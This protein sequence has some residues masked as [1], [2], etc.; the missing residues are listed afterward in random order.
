M[1]M[2]F[3]NRIAKDIDMAESNGIGL[4]TCVKIAEL[5]ACEFSSAKSEE[6]FS[7]SVG[8]IAKGADNN[9]TVL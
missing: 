9:D 5:I 1:T 8:L 2:N 6:G 3:S 4:K 7:A